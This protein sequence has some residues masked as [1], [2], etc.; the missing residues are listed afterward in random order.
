MQLYHIFWARL[1]LALPGESVTF[2]RDSHMSNP[3]WSR[4][5]KCFC[6]D[7]EQILFR[8]CLGKCLTTVCECYIDRRQNHFRSRF[9]DFS[10]N[11]QT[12]NSR[13]RPQLQSQ[14]RSDLCFDLHITVEGFYS[15]LVSVK[16]WILVRF[17]IEQFRYALIW[18]STRRALRELPVNCPHFR[19]NF[20]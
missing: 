9:Q 13:C 2:D 10:S 12:F 17:Y 5:V 1:C 8:T 16:G 19:H 7:R 6:A 4:A 14:T 11:R 18:R 15:A 3:F 20:K